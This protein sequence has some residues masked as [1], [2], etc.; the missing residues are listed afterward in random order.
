M[1]LS[2]S[3]KPVAWGVE[4]CQ[5]AWNEPGCKN[6]LMYAGCL[7]RKEEEA[8]ATHGE[9]ILV[10]QIVKLKKN[11]YRK[12]SFL[13]KISFFHINAYVSLSVLFSNQF[14]RITK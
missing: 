13:T 1:C 7:I 10:F 8:V 5:F 11:I 12:S 2:T 14:F 6:I 3:S 9:I 4:N